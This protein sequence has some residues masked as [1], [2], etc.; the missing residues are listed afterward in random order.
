[1]WYETFTFIGQDNEAYVTSKTFDEKESEA[2]QY[3]VATRTTVNS[4]DARPQYQRLRRLLLNQQMHAEDI[5]SKTSSWCYL[6]MVPI[7]LIFI[8]DDH[9]AGIQTS[10][11]W[12]LKLLGVNT[13]FDS[14]YPACVIASLNRK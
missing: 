5:L 4:E 10:I 13:L 3:D 14:D 8:I 12:E 9:E 6:L 2:L 1:M 7:D 11:V